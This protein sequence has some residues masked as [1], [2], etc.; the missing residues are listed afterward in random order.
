MQ[1]KRVVVTGIGMVTSLG[2]D[3]ATTWHQLLQGTSG[4]GAITHFDATKFNTRFAC[5]VKDL[6]MTGLLDA[7]EVKR[8]DRYLHYA[9]KSAEEAITDAQFEAHPTDAL[10]YGVIYG[11]GMGG[12]NTL[13]VN[14]AGFGAGDG[15]PRYSPFFIPMIITNMAAGILA[16][17]YGFKGVNF[18]TTTACA[19]A[20][21]AIANACYQIR[22]G[23]ADVILTGGSEAAIEV[24]GV[25]GFNALRAMSTRNQSPQ[26]ACRP[27]SA[28][29]D[30]FV[31]GEG[32]GTLVLEE[33]EHA[34]A[35]G[36]HIY[37]EL[38]GIGLTADAYHLTASDPE[39]TGVKNAMQIALNEAGITPQVVDYINTHGTATPIGD[40]AEVKA[41]QEVFGTHA[42]NINITSS[43]SMLGHTMG[44]AGAIEAIVSILSMQHSVV[45]PTINHEPGDEDPNIDYRLKFTFNQAQ[46][47]HI[48][49]AMSN[50]YG[51]GGQN[52]CLIF[53]NPNQ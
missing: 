21:H 23:L 22:M 25:A 46:P 24:S 3:V 45:T 20:A 51:F 38:V 2:N 30:G 29:R 17:R 52:A 47:R 43:K 16:M 10:R 41:I 11:S 7:K 8:Y 32:A 14:I 53:K 48:Q 36:A 35:R 4:A 1:Q 26:T 19:S 5:E 27:F 12:I 28:S 9:I 42:Y 18:A 37:A 33:Y 15:T 31:L 13:D 44:S 40:I 6:D 49:Y 39:G 50:N 34:K